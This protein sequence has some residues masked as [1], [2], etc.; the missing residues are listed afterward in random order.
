MLKYAACALPIVAYAEAGPLNGTVW[1][2]LIS[3]SV[4]PDHIFS[5]QAPAMPTAQAQSSSR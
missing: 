2:I 3:V 4:A 5:A 1:P